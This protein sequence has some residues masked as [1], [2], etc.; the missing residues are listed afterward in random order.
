M[1]HYVPA[2]LD[3]LTEVV[4]YVL[5][6]DNEDDIIEIIDT[7]NAWCKKRLTEEHMAMDM[8]QQVQLYKA[9]LTDYMDEH[10]VYDLS[11]ITKSLFSS[12][13]RLHNATAADDLVECN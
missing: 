9:A 8:M 11:M 3:N 12:E 7:A 6:W 1:E 10:K 13:Q 2:S 4:S 5:D